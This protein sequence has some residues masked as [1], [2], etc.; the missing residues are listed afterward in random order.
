[1]WT[2]VTTTSR[3]DTYTWA[4][5]TAT[6]TECSA[7]QH[8]L[9]LQKEASELAKTQTAHMALMLVFLHFKL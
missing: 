3:V 7:E 8:Q 2:D 9:Q 6:W 1:M 5:E 4:F